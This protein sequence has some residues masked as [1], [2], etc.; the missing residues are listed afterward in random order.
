[1]VD[2][3]V[4]FYMEMFLLKWKSQIVIF[5]NYMQNLKFIFKIYLKL[6]CNKLHAEK[7]IVCWPYKNQ[8]GYLIN[9]KLHVFFKI[10]ISLTDVNFW[11]VLMCINFD[12]KKEFVL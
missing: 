6:I 11:N 3:Y 8:I 7:Q 2:Q 5:E 9:F 4:Y 12:K 1:M 10:F